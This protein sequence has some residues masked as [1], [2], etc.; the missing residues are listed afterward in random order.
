MIESQQQISVV[1][2]VRNEEENL[3]ALYERTSAVF[4]TLD[5]SWELILVDDGSD[6]LSASRIEALHAQDAN[7][8]GIILSRGFGQDA[9]LTAGLDVAK[10][11]A[12]LRELGVTDMDS[13]MPPAQFWAAQ[14][15]SA[16]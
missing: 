6:D 3:D 12:S 10:N 7:V 2:P 13:M 4:S 16:P 15:P 1:V 9:A 14:A 8:K 5:V 11:M